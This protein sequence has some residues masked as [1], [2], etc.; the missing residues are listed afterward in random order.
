MI[1]F[2]RGAEEGVV[3]PRLWQKL[4]GYRQGEVELPPG[5]WSGTFGG[6]RFSGRAAGADLLAAFP[7]ELLVRDAA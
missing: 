3:V 6:G 4:G 7:V 5:R 1:G 2:A